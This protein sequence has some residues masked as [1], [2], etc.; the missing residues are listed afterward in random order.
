MR[1]GYVAVVA[2]AAAVAAGA[3]AVDL[4]ERAGCRPYG[5]S[6]AAVAHVGGRVVALRPTTTTGGCAP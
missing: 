5:A 3:A 4:G 1:P 2:L 6:S